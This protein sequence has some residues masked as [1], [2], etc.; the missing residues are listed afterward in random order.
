MSLVY[1]SRDKWLSRNSSIR[2]IPLL[3]RCET[4]KGA[5]DVQGERRTKEEQGESVTT[6]RI[7]PEKLESLEEKRGRSSIKA[8]INETE[9]HRSARYLIIQRCATRKITRCNELMA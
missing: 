3:T 2:P 4:V 5:E 6:R 7:H 1:D 9:F 8:S